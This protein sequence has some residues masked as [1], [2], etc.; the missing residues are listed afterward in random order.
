VL[1]KTSPVAS[2]GTTVA[3]QLKFVPHAPP[4]HWTELGHEIEVVVGINVLFVV[5]VELVVAVE[6]IEVVVVVDVLFTVLVVVDVEFVVVVEVPLTTSTLP[7]ARTSRTEGFAEPFA[8]KNST[9]M[10]DSRK[11]DAS[12]NEPALTAFI[13]PFHL[14]Q[15]HLSR[16]HC[17][18]V[19]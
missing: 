13:R 18:S 12:S 6:V 5:D 8:S 2:L 15:S 1:K 19:D 10:A 9:P 4:A 7:E 16:P 11:S 3:K 14:R 17:D